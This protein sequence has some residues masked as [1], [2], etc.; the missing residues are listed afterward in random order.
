MIRYY[1]TPISPWSY[2]GNQ[3]LSEMAVKQGVE[4]DY[5]PVNILKVFDESGGLPLGKRPIQRKLYRMTELKRWRDHLNIDLTLEPKFF[6]TDDQLASRM[7]IACESQEEKF[8]LSQALMYAI[9]AEDRDISDVATLKS[10]CNELGL[11]ADVL[12]ARGQSDETRC[13]YEANIQAAIEDNVFGAPSY[14]YKDELY[15][16]QDRLD[17]LEVALQT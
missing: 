3:R 7:I 9:W 5:R 2:L 11:D 12:I 17:F 14:L 16:G 15:W 1:F 6:P 10:I 4:I 13:Q 8:K